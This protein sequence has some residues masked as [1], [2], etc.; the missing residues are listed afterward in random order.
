[1]KQKLKDMRKHDCVIS[2]DK[3][4]LCYRAN[5]EIV[6]KLN[7]CNELIDSDDCFKLVRVP[8]DEALFANSFHLMIKYPR[9]GGEQ[10]FV[11]RKFA[12]LK[13]RL[14]SMEGANYVWL[15]VENWVFYEIFIVSSRSKC[16][17]LSCVDYIAN[18]LELSLNNVTD[19]HIALDTTVDFA[20]KIRH[21]QFCDDYD[22][23]LNGKVRSDKKEVLNE[24]LH[25]QTGDQHRLRTL[26]IYINPK[27]Q[28]GLSLKIYDKKRELEKSNKEYIPKWSGI[29]DKNYRVELTLKNEHL[30]EYYQNNGGTILDE[31]LMVTLAS[32]RESQELL[33]DMLY[34]F[35]NRLLRFR[36]S[37]KVISIFEL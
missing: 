32:Q 16:N 35:S 23:I 1:M 20:K 30:K 10:G 22:V 28:D 2:I 8:S 31:A 13:T 27:K 4:T 17:W 25:L 12:T 14:R 3:L 36:Y 26:T 19:L 33:F 15:Y 37:G 5:D 18:E 24:I 6:Q 7:E 21:A 9:G 29:T 34:Y 11:V